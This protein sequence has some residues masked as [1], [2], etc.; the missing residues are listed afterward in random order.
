LEKAREGEGEW[1]QGPPGNQGE[2]VDLGLA[3]G[4]SLRRTQEGK[5]IEGQFFVGGGVFLSGGKE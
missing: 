1:N 4:G 2:K 5:M 3:R